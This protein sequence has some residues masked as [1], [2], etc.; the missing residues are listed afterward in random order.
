MI[1]ENFEIIS[2]PK[3]NENQNPKVTYTNKYQKNVSFTYDYKLVCADDKLI[4]PLRH[5]Q[6]KMQFIIFLM[7]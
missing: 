3:N 4:K 5:T 2:V 1:Y 7:V 6:A